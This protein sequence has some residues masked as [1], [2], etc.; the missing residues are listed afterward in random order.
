MTRPLRIAYEGALYHLTSRGNE[1]KP[2][3]HTD[4]DRIHFLFNLSEYVHR[5]Q[6]ICYDYCLMTNHYHLVVETPI[7][8]ISDGMQLLNGAYAT[9][10]NRVHA[11]VGHV[12]QGRF[13]GILVEKE[14]YL[15]ELSRYV[16]LN[17]VRAGMCASP[18]DYRW[19]S[20][21]ARMGLELRPSFL[22]SDKVL[23]L[24][25]SDLLEARQRYAGFVS[26]GVDK[27]IWDDLK[28]GMYLGSDG[29]VEAMQSKADASRGI[30]PT[31]LL[32]PRPPLE[33]LLTRPNGLSEAFEKH[34]YS[35]RAIA[36]SCGVS[37]STM[38]RVLRG[39]KTTLP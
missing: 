34:N 19:S 23:D 5:F 30:V 6:W 38:L 28:A 26:D 33:A 31:H 22:A 39:L 17:P 36:K 13:T 24:F 18:A 1:K 25:S 3:Y 20:Y 14:A 32:P 27:R 10:F 4:Q 2:I 15:R 29:F 37:H 35:V 12:F 7:A 9:Y 21:R 16:V 8:N 11:R